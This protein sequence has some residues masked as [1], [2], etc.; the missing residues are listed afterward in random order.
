MF[1]ITASQWYSLK[2]YLDIQGTQKKTKNK[3]TVPRGVGEKANDP[4]L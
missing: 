2:Q 1:K 3:V 4:S